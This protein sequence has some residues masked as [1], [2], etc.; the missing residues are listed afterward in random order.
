MSWGVKP[1]AATDTAVSLPLLAMEAS[2][3]QSPVVWSLFSG[4][5]GLDL[6]LGSA[7]LAPTV[8]AEI[9][10]WCCRS[11][12]ANR[13]SV[14]LLDGDIREM[15]GPTL[16]SASNHSGDVFAIVGGPPC[17]SFSS[18]GK[19]ASLADPRGVLVFEFF[20]IV[21]EVQP[22][23][24]LFENVANLLT[25]AVRH[26]PIAERPGKNWNLNAYTADPRGNGDAPP[27]EPDEMSGSAIRSLLESVADLG[28][29][30]S[31]GLVNAAEV[32][33]PQRRLRFVMLGSRDGP[34]PSLPSR[35]HGEEPHLAPFATARGAIED[36]QDDP[37]PGSEYVEA[38]RRVFAQIPPGGNWR[39]LPEDAQRKAMGRAFDAGG[40][41]TGFFRRLAWD[42]PSPTITTKPN[43]KSSAMCHPVATRPLSVRECARLQGFPDEW[44]FPGPMNKQYEQ[45]GN[46][47]PV[48]LG[49]ALGASMLAGGI[50]DAV[51][52]RQAML[53]AAQAKLRAAARNK[54]SMPS[55]EAL[56]A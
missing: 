46:A 39:S 16:R 19:R 2:E 35:T 27:M 38:T 41:R 40:G 34:P 43:R 23:Y 4:S 29:A 24:F 33:A 47:V 13:P 5:M 25:A 21:A 26:R 10:P 20:R 12:A 22:L 17:Q 31:F 30:I 42:E 6:G 32:G 3:T 1:K 48:K 15:D 56:L 37:G 54:R 45:I 49:E 44:K 28:Y 55:R 53:D 36:L 8:A 9:D 14:T 50:A 18:G 7:G 52:S 11:I 51:E